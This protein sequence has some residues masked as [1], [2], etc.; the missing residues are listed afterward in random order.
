MNF[1]CAV[2][3]PSVEGGD[4]PGLQQEDLAAL[5]EGELHVP[6]PAEAR[7]QL[8]GRPAHRHR[9]LVRH[10]QRRP[11]GLAQIDLES[12]LNINIRL[13]RQSIAA[14]CVH[15]RTSVG[16]LDDLLAL[17]ADGPPGHAE[18]APG[19]RLPLH[20]YGVGLGQRGHHAL[21]NNSA[22]IVIIALVKTIT[23]PSP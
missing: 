10:A 23:S 22:I 8:R 18:P 19:P 2:T 12:P 6:G 3:C 14:Y 17:G 11:L 16:R 7:L 1:H 4:W 9:G 15:K 21:I 13:L 20:S 5:A